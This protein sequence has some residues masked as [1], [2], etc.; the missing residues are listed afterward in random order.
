MKPAPRVALPDILWAIG[1]LPIVHVGVPLT[2]ERGGELNMRD[3]K[4]RSLKI[5][6][7]WV[8]RGERHPLRTFDT[9]SRG[10]V[11]N[12]V[13]ASGVLNSEFQNWFQQE[14]S[15]VKIKY[16]QISPEAEK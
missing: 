3:F 2:F 9:S 14:K 7:Q 4:I 6:Q 1:E 13:C 15:K 12:S 16:S 5:I 8:L 11:N 10:I